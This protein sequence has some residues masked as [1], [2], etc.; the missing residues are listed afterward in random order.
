M[1]DSMEIHVFRFWRRSPYR[2]SRDSDIGDDRQSRT[3]NPEASRGI[4]SHPERP[5]V[6]RRTN[7]ISAIHTDMS[8]IILSGPLLSPKNHSTITQLPTGTSYCTAFEPWLSHS[9]VLSKLF[10]IVVR[11]FVL[12][13]CVCRAHLLV[14]YFADCYVMSLLSS[15]SLI[16]LLCH[17]C[18][19]WLSSWLSSSFL[20]FVIVIARSTVNRNEELNDVYR[21]TQKNVYHFNTMTNPEKAHQE[22]VDELDNLQEY[23]VTWFCACVCCAIPGLIRLALIL[24]SALTTFRKETD[25]GDERELH[26]FEVATPMNLVATDTLVEEAVTLIPKL[27]TIS[28][29]YH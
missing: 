26:P 12:V 19:L 2:Q 28:R 24:Y 11:S 23:V 25:V 14:L 29:G 5:R 6:W 17:P 20:L 15:L 8:K 1:Q 13:W 3:R 7:P 18:R 27:V 16:F 22:L 21:K 9:G 4:P 10:F